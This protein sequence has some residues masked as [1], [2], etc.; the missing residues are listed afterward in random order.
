MRV[1]W[2]PDESLTEVRLFTHDPDEELGP[3]DR[4]QGEIGDIKGEGSVLKLHRDLEDL[5]DDDDGVIREENLMDYTEPSEIDKGDMT[6]EDRSRNYIKRGGTQE[7]SS[8]EKQAQNHREA[9]TLMVFYTSPADIPSSPKEPPQTD[10]D[11]PVTEV[12]SFGELPDHIKVRQERYY[13]AVNPKPA[14]VAAAPPLAQ[15][16]QFD[17]SNLLK[18]IQNASQ[19]QSTPPPPPPQPASQAPMSDLER[20]ISMFR[21][22]Q[23]QVPQI[24]QFPAVSQAPAM[25]G[26]DFQKILAV[27]SAQKQMPP[28]PIVPQVPQ[29]QPAIAPNLAAIISQFANQNQ[30]TSSSQPSGHQYEE[31]ERK[32]MRETDGSEESSDDR[33]GYAKRSKFGAPNKK[34]PKAG[35]VPCRYWREGKCLKGDNCTFRHDPLN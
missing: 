17:I 32:R 29:A 19:Q 20:T 34:H 21:Q 7:P 28:A 1:R 30:Q 8:P 25:Q 11:E 24:P 6:S 12:I 10:T 23:P 3:G 35:L 18:I 4:S 26:F 16:S 13:A 33:F 31:P 15:A 2:K 9:T 22:Q 27:M 14:P 5:E